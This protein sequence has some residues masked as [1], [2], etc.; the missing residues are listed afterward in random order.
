MNHAAEAR[1]PPECPRQ[2]WSRQV[3]AVAQ[4]MGAGM[5]DN[6]LETLLRQVGHALPP[7]SPLPMTPSLMGLSPTQT[8]RHRTLQAAGPRLLFLI[9]PAGTATDTS[10]RVQLGLYCKAASNGAHCYSCLQA[11]QDVLQLPE[12]ASAF[13]DSM[14]ALSI[15]GCTSSHMAAQRLWQEQSYSYSEAATAAGKQHTMGTAGM[16]LPPGQ[17]RRAEAQQAGARQSMSVLLALQQQA[18]ALV[19]AA[20]D[21]PERAVRQLSEASQVQDRLQ[22]QQVAT[23]LQSTPAASGPTAALPAMAEQAAP[24]SSQTAGTAEGAPAGGQ[25]AL[26]QDLAVRQQALLGL[27]AHLAQCHAAAARHTSDSGQVAAL[28]PMCTP[29]RSGSLVPRQAVPYSLAPEA[30]LPLGTALE[31]PPTAEQAASLRRQL[32]PLEAHAG[33]CM[34]ASLPQPAQPAGSAHASPQWQPRGLPAEHT[35]WQGAALQQQPVA[36]AGDAGQ[37]AGPGSPLLCMAVAPPAGL[38][39]AGTADGSICIW[40]MGIT[41]L[42][43]QQH[44][45]GVVQG[46]VLGEAPALCTH[47]PLRKPRVV[48]SVSLSTPGAFR[49]G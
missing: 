22:A 45:S 5:L 49:R 8:L 39:A 25:A 6:V 1:L 47:W 30:R 41:G 28:R 33:A 17:H 4:E 26:A 31:Q 27:A 7:S 40:W 3:A 32:L 46:A 43:L 42:Q 16:A 21:I 38:L 19:G 15:M 10:W 29:G 9:K 20:V 35:F 14:L 34:P 12:A 37:P 23:V 44:L 24:G 2:P 36:A 13:A 48:S 11:A 18:V